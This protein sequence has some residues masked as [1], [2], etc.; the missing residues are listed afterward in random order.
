[1]RRADKET[2][3][4]TPLAL[5]LSEETNTDSA[6]VLAILYTENLQR[7][8]WFRRLERAKG[9]I[10]RRGTYGVMQI[11]SDHPISDEESIRLALA[12]RL[13]G[14]QVKPDNS[15]CY[16]SSDLERVLRD[17]NNSDEFI[18]LASQFYALLYPAYVNPIVEGE[19]ERHENADIR[20]AVVAR[21]RTLM[22]MV[23]DDNAV[24]RYATT[25]SIQDL[26]TLTAAL[27]TVPL[28]PTDEDIEIARQVRE[29][30]LNEPM[31]PDRG[32]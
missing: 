16:D 8:R 15:N 5:S 4:L 21:L 29:K 32:K 7:P 25:A 26:T 27:A 9:K 22:R 24:V 10:L 19:T 14:Q 1:M 13:Q 31:Y 20:A 28:T 6:L 2:R 30:I 12:D 18:R 3:T 23:S 11:T 17:Y